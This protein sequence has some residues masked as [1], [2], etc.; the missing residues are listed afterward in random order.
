MVI[1]HNQAFS[2]VA[3]QTQKPLFCWLES[4]VWQ[5]SQSLNWRRVAALF[6]SKVTY[7]K[8]MPVSVDATWQLWASKRKMPGQHPALMDACKVICWPAPGL[9]LGV[10]KGVKTMLSKRWKLH[11]SLQNTRGLGAI[12]LLTKETCLCYFLTNQSLFLGTWPTNYVVGTWFSTG[13]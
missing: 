9:C 13:K 10:E 11:V 12:I 7:P 1:N 4:H 2:W 8:M 5:V 3:T 6:F